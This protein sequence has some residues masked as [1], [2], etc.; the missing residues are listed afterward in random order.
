VGSPL[1]VDITSEAGMPETDIDRVSPLRSILVSFSLSSAP[2]DF[3]KDCGGCCFL[4]VTLSLTVSS[5]SSSFSVPFPF[6][7]EEEEEE[8]VV[9]VAPEV[10]ADV[11]AGSSRRSTSISEAGLLACDY[12]DH[13]KNQRSSPPREKNSNKHTFLAFL[14]PPLRVV[15]VGVAEVVSVDLGVVAVDFLSVTF[16]GGTAPGVFEVEVTA[17]LSFN[18]AG[19]DRGEEDP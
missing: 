9:V 5:S 4:G 11:A 16:F 17:G 2:E 1:G 15:V 18:G 12:D 8:E 7:A 14:D 19:G 6:S 13:Q 3:D 10:A